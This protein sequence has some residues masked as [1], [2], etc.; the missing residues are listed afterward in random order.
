MPRRRH[1][2]KEVEDDVPTS[3]SWFWGF[4]CLI[5]IIGLGVM[6]YLFVTQK[7]KYE[8]TIKEDV[9]YLATAKS[10]LLN[11]K[12]MVLDASR[13]TKLVDSF[14]L[15][16]FVI[17]SGS[18]SSCLDDYGATKAK[19]KN[20]WIHPCDIKNPNQQWQ[21]DSNTKSIRNPNKKLC[22]ALADVKKGSNVTLDKCNESNPQKWSYDMNKRQLKSS[23]LCLMQNGSKT[24][25]FMDDCDDSKVSQRFFFRDDII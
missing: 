15:N 1:H 21:Y 8:Q 3:T 11:M 16:N 12:G 18:M 20:C 4:L 24:D 6:I 14:P 9:K 19:E 25:F 23:G 13:Q 10:D 22:L 17:E 7:K 5:L 2:D